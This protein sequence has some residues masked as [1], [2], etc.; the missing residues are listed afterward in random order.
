[1]SNKLTEPLLSPS[2][3]GSMAAFVCTVIAVFTGTLVAPFTGFV[4]TTPMLNV[5]GAA[6]VVK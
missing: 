1:M 5:C 6:A 4:L 2:V 3:V